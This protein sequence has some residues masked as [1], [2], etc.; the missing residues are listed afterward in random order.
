MVCVRHRLCDPKIASASVE[1]AEP[2]G[3]AQ[4]KA[5]GSGVSDAL[6]QYRSFGVTRYSPVEEVMVGDF[7]LTSSIARTQWFV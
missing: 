4:S 2:P 6:R 7:S 5:L 1:V 3:R